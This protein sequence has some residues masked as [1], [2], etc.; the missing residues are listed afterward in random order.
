MAGVVLSKQF[1]I[2][3]RDAVKQ[4]EAMQRSGHAFRRN[5][6]PSYFGAGGLTSGVITA[7]TLIRPNVWRYKAKR[8]YFDVDAQAMA[9]LDPAEVEV[10]CY[11]WREQANTATGDQNSG[12]TVG[13]SGSATIT[14]KPVKIGCP[15]FLFKV[16]SQKPTKIKTPPASIGINDP[17]VPMDVSVAYLFEVDN[18]VSVGCGA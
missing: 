4:V 9:P 7:A 18:A 13:V 5:P 3:V 10:T 1:A 8:R 16:S 15:V 12:V 6:A 2:R 11:N 14:L 17:P